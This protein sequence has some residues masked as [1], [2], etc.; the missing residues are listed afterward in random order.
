M[1]ENVILAP[2]GAGL[3]TMERWTSAA[4]LR[5]MRALLT[6]E[7]LTRRLLRETQW[8]I[9]LSRTVPD[10]LARKPILIERPMG[11]EDSSRGWSVFMVLQ[12]LVIVDGGIRE[13]AL[14]LPN[15]K[16]MVRE[17]RIAEV[18]PTPSAGPE[19]RDQLRATVDDYVKVIG[20]VRELRTAQHHPHPWF[21]TLDL[22]GWHALAAMHTR[23]HR[24]QMQRI[25]AALKSER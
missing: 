12:H 16:P 11:L 23:A 1:S 14:A 20:T 22:R 5:S 21:G 9:D 18:K 24:R 19:Q 15:D 10:E 8:I 7:A 17:V 6:K 3:P 13:L 4:L 2:P 25:L